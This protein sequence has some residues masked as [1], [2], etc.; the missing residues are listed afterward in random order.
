MIPFPVGQTSSLTWL[1][2][3]DSGSW[4]NQ[5][6]QEKSMAVALGLRGHLLPGFSLHME[7]LD[8]M[9]AVWLR[10]SLPPQPSLGYSFHTAR[11]ECCWITISD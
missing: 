2:S 11:L 4:G 3:L 5:T 8:P 6:L 7:L 9:G 10:L 1:M